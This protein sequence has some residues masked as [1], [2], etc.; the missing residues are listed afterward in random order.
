MAS[1]NSGKPE[2][3]IESCVTVKAV[4]CK[5]RNKILRAPLTSREILIPQCGH[6][7]TLFPPNL[8]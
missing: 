5:A 4:A 1:V 3:T 6:L 7:N 2:S 8:G